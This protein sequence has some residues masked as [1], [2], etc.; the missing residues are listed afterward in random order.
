MQDISTVKKIKTIY[1][2]LSSKKIVEIKPW[3][4]V[5]VNLIVPYSKSIRQQQP[6]GAIITNNFILACMMMIYPSTGWFEVVEVLKFDLNGVTCNNVE[7]VEKLS[8][9]GSH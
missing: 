9:R 4:T 1:E 2:P 3:D 8:A 5:H 6:C 7:Y